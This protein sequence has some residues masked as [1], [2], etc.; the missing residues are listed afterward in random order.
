MAEAT[1]RA[2]VFP[3]QLSFKHLVQVWVAWSQWQ[4]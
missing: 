2:G 1:E 4:R 3:R